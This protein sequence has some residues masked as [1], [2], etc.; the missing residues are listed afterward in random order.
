MSNGTT[1]IEI[2]PEELER[3][4]ELKNWYAREIK[5][6]NTLKIEKLTNIG[7]SSLNLE[8]TPTMTVQEIRETLMN[9][10]QFL[11]SG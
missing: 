3:F 10:E 2:N 11:C 5:G 6:E 7:E 4:Q 8:A 1:M 9:D